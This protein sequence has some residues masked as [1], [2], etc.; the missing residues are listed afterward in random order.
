MCGVLQELQD[1]SPHHATEAAD[2]TLQLCKTPTAQLDGG[3]VGGSVAPVGD[4][5]TVGEDDARVVGVSDAPVGD[6]IAVGEDDVRVV[7]DGDAVVTQA[8]ALASAEQVCIF[9]SLM[10]H[11][12]R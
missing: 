4:E 6:D 9:C 12:C 2:I 10:Y 1:S 3:G 11:M 8:E 5:V 7:G